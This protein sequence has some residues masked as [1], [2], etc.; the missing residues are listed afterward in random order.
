MRAEAR[1]ARAEAQPAEGEAEEQPAPADRAAK[2]LA[3]RE[4]RN[5]GYLA[6]EGKL[7]YLWG[8]VHPLGGVAP[9]ATDTP[10]LLRVELPP[11]QGSATGRCRP[12][13]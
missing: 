3:D 9:D 13:R 4:R 6:R 10:L 7:V 5:A 11:G 1:A 2:C 8:G 12:R